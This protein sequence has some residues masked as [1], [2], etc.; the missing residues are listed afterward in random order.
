MERS[1][2]TLGESA[3]PSAEAYSAFVQALTLESIDVVKLN[4]ERRAPGD[5]SHT[6][7]ELSAAWQRAED[8]ML[9]RYEVVA[10]L[11]D[12]DENDYG[13]VEAAVIVSARSDVEP[14]LAAL[15][16]FGMT[17]GSFMA[18]PYLREVIASTALRLGFSGVLL[19]VLTQQ[20]AP[21]GQD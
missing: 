6:R 5:A 19:P 4:A 16:Q 10:H 9:W 7:F 3:A 14:D 18:H 15:Q 20:P 1:L 17:S 2:E 21:E 13:T 8:R 11:T 12:P